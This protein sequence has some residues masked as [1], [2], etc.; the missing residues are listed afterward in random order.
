MYFTANHS[1]FTCDTLHRG[2]SQLVQACALHTVNGTQPLLGRIPFPAE[3]SQN[4]TVCLWVSFQRGTWRLLSLLVA[5][6]VIH[7]IASLRFTSVGQKLHHMPA[8][9]LRLSSRQQTH[10][11]DRPSSRSG[12]HADPFS[13]SLLVHVQE[14]RSDCGCA[15]LHCTA[16]EAAARL[17]AIC[18]FPAVSCCSHSCRVAAVCGNAFHSCSLMFVFFFHL[19]ETHRAALRFKAHCKTTA[20]GGASVPA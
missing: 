10:A 8:D 14:F 13:L 18:C 20:A 16:G 17:N 2:A 15:L 12:P 3:L 4:I 11:H 9:T 19:L 6:R 5:A 7:F 1:E